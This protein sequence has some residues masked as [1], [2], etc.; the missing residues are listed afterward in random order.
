MVY[1]TF[2]GNTEKMAR[3]VAEGAKQVQG[4]DVILKK[5]AEVTLEDFVSSDAVAFGSPNT[6]GDMAGALSDFFDRTWSVH[7]QVAGRPAVAFTSENPGET[8]AL[9]DIERFFNYYGLKKVSEGVVSAGA[10]GTVKSEECK[11]LGR[12]LAEAARK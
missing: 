10:L 2:T 4:V 7:G 8:G 3:A 9:R 5:A 1:H 11:K 12:K 6:F